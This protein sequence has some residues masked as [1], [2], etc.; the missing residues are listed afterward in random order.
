[1][2]PLSAILAMVRIV[3]QIT[4]PTVSIAQLLP[5]SPKSSNAA[6]AV[7]V[8]SGETAT[9]TEVIPAKAN[10]APRRRSVR[11][12]STNWFDTR[13][14]IYLLSICYVAY[15]VNDIIRLTM[16]FIYPK[17]PSMISYFAFMT[18]MGFLVTAGALILHINTAYAWCAE[19]AGFEDRCLAENWV[20]IPDKRGLIFDMYTQ[21]AKGCKQG[22][23][24]GLDLGSIDDGSCMNATA[25]CI[26]QS[27]DLSKC[28]PDNI[29]TIGMHCDN[30]VLSS[31]QNCN[32]LREMQQQA[33]DDAE[34]SALKLATENGGCTIDTS[35]SQTT[36]FDQKKK[37]EEVINSC[38]KADYDKVDFNKGVKYFNEWGFQDYEKCLDK[39]LISTAKDESECVARGGKWIGGTDGAQKPRCEST[40]TY[41]GTYCSDGSTPNEKTGKCANGTNPTKSPRPTITLPSVN[42]DGCGE[43][44]TVLIKC[45]RKEE[46]VTVIGNVLRFIIQALTVLIGVAAVGGIAWQSVQYARAQDEQ[47]VVS[48]ARTKIRNIV[49]GIFAYGFM[50]AILN[51]LIPGGVI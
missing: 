4:H 33:F 25:T 16:K 11:N 51:W 13:C 45:D 50:I 19:N 39:Q 1:M 49:I 36:Q 6:D 7:G 44:E 20:S 21:M 15:G 41:D 28:T 9:N 37:C 8:D 34:A 10:N 38:Q 47:S 5:P 17:T 40:K 46:G 32:R 27:I 14:N 2:K 35:A 24:S 18:L 26:Q 3:G 43:A 12:P 22:N 29:A 42:S 48:D 30:G 31:T 23:P